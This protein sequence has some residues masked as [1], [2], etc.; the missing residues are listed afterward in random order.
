MI[1]MIRE[2]NESDYNIVNVLGR[3]VD[4]LFRLNFSPVSKCFV[5]EVDEEVVGF[6]IADIFDDRAEII[7]IAVDVMYR[8]KKIGDK[9][10][11]HIIDICKNNKCDNIT[12][13]VKI[14][15]KPALKLYK[16]NE[17]KIISVRKKYYKDGNTDAY[18]MQRKF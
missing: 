7:D 17:F 8:N 10:L 12:L 14:D 11:K 16:N 2:Y 13:E 5:Y 3:D 1:E 15:N 6:I 18:L 4:P 9:L